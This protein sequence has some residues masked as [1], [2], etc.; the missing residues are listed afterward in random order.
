M[1][2]LRKELE[3]VRA[4]SVPRHLHDKLQL[5]VEQLQVRCRLLCFENGWLLND[6][7]VVGATARDASVVRE[8]V[9]FSR[10]RVGR[11]EEVENE[12]SHRC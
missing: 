1:A 3:Q 9:V 8:A 7:I 10:V 4:T 6:V 11:R 2:A 5:D 12:R